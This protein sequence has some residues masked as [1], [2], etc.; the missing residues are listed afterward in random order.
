MPKLF[1]FGVFSMVYVG[2]S[3]FLEPAGKSARFQKWE[4]MMKYSVLLAGFILMAATT[5]FSEVEQYIGIAIK[6]LWHCCRRIS[7][8]LDK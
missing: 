8:F 4:A 7:I 1:R 5:A 2:N 6:S 3:F